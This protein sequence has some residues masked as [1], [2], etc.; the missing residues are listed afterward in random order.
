[1]QFHDPAACEERQVIRTRRQCLPVEA[2]L[3]DEVVP[4]LETVAPGTLANLPR[5]FAHQQGFVAGDQ[6]GR[7]KPPGEAAF[8]LL[9]VEFHEP[10]SWESTMPLSSS[11]TGMPSCTG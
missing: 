11:N 6:V 3:D 9:A 7:L 1:M 4:L 8:K 5:G 2:P 10:S